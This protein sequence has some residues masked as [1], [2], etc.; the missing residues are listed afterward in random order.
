MVVVKSK[1][2]FRPFTNVQENSLYIEE[3]ENRELTYEKKHEF[4]IGG[5]FGFI[6]NR[7]NIAVDWYKRNNFDLIGVINTKGVGGVTQK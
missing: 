4:N 3:L 7:L 5:E 2:P 6:D 1:T